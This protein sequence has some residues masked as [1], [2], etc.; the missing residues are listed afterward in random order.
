MKTVKELEKLINES[1]LFLIDRVRDN[2]LFVAEER[3][4]LADLA[5]LLSLVR[6]DFH[7][8]G[9][10]VFVTAKACIKSYKA[11]CGAFLNYFNVALKKSLFVQKAKE[12]ISE[13]RSGLTL[14][15]KTDRIIRRIVQY[16]KICG[17]DHDKSGL[18]NKIADAL[19]I[20]Q[21]KVT[22]AIATNRDIFVQSGNA[23]TI[24]KD[25]K[26][27]ELFDFI[28][29]KT[30]SPDKALI[31]ELSVQMHI[32]AIDS[33][34]RRQQDRIK[35]LLSKLLTARLLKDLGDIQLIEKVISGI[36]FINK[37]LYTCYKED[38]TV[39]TAREIAESYGVMEASASRTLNTFIEKIKRNS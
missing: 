26:E 27:G 8:I 13:T 25:G 30:S 7:I 2:E 37:Q 38:R 21:E 36:S 22:Q 18:V 39:P 10:E 19:N 16:T 12:E 20:Q 33:V 31:D 23:P 9:Y 24:N 17:E 14:D 32:K 3:R 28:A 35:P 34:F 4:F 11:E 6:K 15:Q 29:D 1:A 5:E